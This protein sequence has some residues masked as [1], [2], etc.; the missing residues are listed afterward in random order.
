MSRFARFACFAV[1]LVAMLPT[2]AA[3]AQQG[4]AF[5]DIQIVDRTVAPDDSEFGYV[6]HAFEITNHSPDRTRRVTLSAPAGDSGD[7]HRIRQLSRSVEL[8]PGASARVSILQ[9]PLPL[10][11]AHFS[12]TIDG[13]RQRER[14][15]TSAGRPGASGYRTNFGSF[16]S[17]TQVYV[18]ASPGAMAVPAVAERAPSVGAEFHFRRHEA[19][20]ANWSRGWLSYSAFAAVVV[21]AGEWDAAPAELQASLL[22]YARAGGVLCLLGSLELGNVTHGPTES[23]GEGDASFYGFGVVFRVDRS[24]LSYELDQSPWSHL[25]RA[26]HD[27]HRELAAR[28]SAGAAN[29]DFPV[30]DDTDVPIRGL[31]GLLIVFALVAGPLNLVLL[32]RKQRRI[33]LLWTTP[34]ISLV[35]CGSVFA[36]T[37]FADGITPMV[38]V[39]TVTLL[40]QERREAT[41][42]G[43]LGYYAPL[44][45][46]GGLRFDD[47]TE[48]TPQVTNDVRHDTG[49][50]RV[51]EWARG[52]QHLASGWVTAGVTSHFRIRRVAT[53][54]RRLQVERD[55]TGAPLL[56]N[57]LE[58]DIHEVYF[59]DTDG[60]LYRAG[61]IADGEQ[62]AAAPAEL[63]DRGD[64]HRPDHLR[65][66]FRTNWAARP[67]Y[68]EVDHYA[69]ALQPGG[70]IAFIDSTPF[71]DPSLSRYHAREQRSVV[72]GRLGDAD[73][74][75]P[76]ASAE[77]RR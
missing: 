37:L 14:L 72:I 11:G 55:P 77:G 66:I 68:D 43:W 41:T 51:V 32:T 73:F 46:R 31:F 2:S 57:R 60:R 10:G 16:Q 30:I 75:A 54:R 25:V 49:R 59:L 12:V 4:G 48:L 76:R 13:Q 53:D 35:F 56:V 28:R 33:W 64:R 65:G 17:T 45:P 71:I 27:T 58:A 23:F 22:D 5:G 6:D 70:Y 39:G 38:R 63:D 62:T 52:E 18:L 42:L 69:R 29:R 7:L 67:P 47:R 1:L 8:A 3:H 36:Y 21:T 50:P 26:A 9:P 34:A 40:D 19:P 44:T 20:L 61:G 24:H 74:T 15:A